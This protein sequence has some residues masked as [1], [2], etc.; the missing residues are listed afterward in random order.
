MRSPPDAKPP[1]DGPGGDP[2]IL[3]QDRPR[4]IDRT[5]GVSQS[6]E[7]E[8][9]CS[10]GRGCPEVVDRVR[11]AHVAKYVEGCE[12]HADELLATAR[13]FAELHRYGCPVELDAA[14]R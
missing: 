3:D 13:R 2:D 14:E 1:P 12:H 8:V 11:A 9:R 7:V 10:D 6:T 5:A 4:R